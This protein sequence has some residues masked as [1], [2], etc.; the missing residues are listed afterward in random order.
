MHVIFFLWRWIEGNLKESIGQ[1]FFFF[2]LIQK[3]KKIA[4]VS[5]KGKYTDSS[6]LEELM[7][8]I[9]EFQW[10]NCFFKSYWQVNS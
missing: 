6:K 5:F 10:E 3:E 2:F 1:S 7:Y 8:E 9:E 4:L